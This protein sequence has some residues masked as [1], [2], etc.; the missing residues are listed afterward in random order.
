MLN[1]NVRLNN[2]TPPR[3]P[4]TDPRTGLIAREWYLFLL[5]LFTLV[6]GGQN[7]TSLTDLQVGPPPVSVDELENRLP[8]GHGVNPDDGALLAQVSEL[9]KRLQALEASLGHMSL[10]AELDK[11][12]QAL[13]VL[14]GQMAQLLSQM[15]DVNAQKPSDGD[16]LIYNGTLGQWEQD[17]RSYLMLE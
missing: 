10:L 8:S 9:D 13:E 1:A 3:V 7:T 12:L 11:R 6:G 4:L 14:P 2:I 5:N 16:K 15:A 17:S